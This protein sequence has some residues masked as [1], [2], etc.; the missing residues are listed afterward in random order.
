MKKFF[1][2]AIVVGLCGSFFLAG[3]QEE[4]KGVS[5]VSSGVIYQAEQS[6]LLPAQYE[7]T[8]KTNQVRLELFNTQ[9][10]VDTENIS[11]LLVNEGDKD[12]EYGYMDLKLEVKKKDHWY[13]IPVNEVPEILL[14]L[15]VNDKKEHEILLDQMSSFRYNSQYGEP[16]S[17][18]RYDYH[19]GKY[20]L[21]FE[22]PEIGWTFSELSLIH[23]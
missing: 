16:S 12:I 5:E 22:T 19:P 17:L 18:Y 7:E 15:S 23:I 1:L 14:N 9:Y 4:Q 2:M 13:S 21:V 6:G 3:C 11:F 10:P 20:R 8:K